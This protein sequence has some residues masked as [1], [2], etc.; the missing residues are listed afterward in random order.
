[1]IR[2]FI[3]LLTFKTRHCAKMENSN[4]KSDM[5]NVVNK[6][7][8]KVKKFE[9]AKLL[10]QK[11][12][13]QLEQELIYLEWEIEE[14]CYNN[15][16]EV[17]NA[18]SKIINNAEFYAKYSKY[19]LAKLKKEYEKINKEEVDKFDLDC[20]PYEKFLKNYPYTTKIFNHI[21]AVLIFVKVK[22]EKEITTWIPRFIGL[23]EEKFNRIKVEKIIADKK[24]NIVIKKIEE[25]TR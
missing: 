22:N 12:L 5:F 21:D 14:G 4:K 10:S 25:K 15:C 16:S 3:E 1:M 11:E 2:K 9:W 20:V 8:K 13:H 23:Q 18:V 7:I 6:A 24:K 17:D 19:N